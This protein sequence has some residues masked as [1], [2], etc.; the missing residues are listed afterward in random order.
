MTQRLIQHSFIC[1]LF[2]FAINLIIAALK[3]QFVLIWTANII[4]GFVFAFV[5]TNAAK[6]NADKKSL[7]FMLLSGGLY[8]T[9]A[10]IA[11]G[12]SFFGDKVYMCF[13]I[14]SIIGAI[15]MLFL[16]KLL[17]DNKL[18]FIAGLKYAVLTGLA[19]S[20][21]PVIGDLLH[22]SFD[23]LDKSYWLAMTF[24][25]SIFLI[26]QPL[27]AWTIIRQKDFR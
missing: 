19:S 1:G 7:L 27:F 24:T 18:S 4:P 12:Y 5:L 14:A 26:W 23:I 16:Y 20:I 25:L 17:L 9:I 21:L 6:S 10:W 2:T 8:I 13:P 3:L 22:P 15:S 11:T